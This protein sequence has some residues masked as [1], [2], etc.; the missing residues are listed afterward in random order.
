MSGPRR[1]PIKALV[2][3][4]G[5]AKGMVA[6][7]ALHY[8]ERNFNL[9]IISGTSIG[10]V[11]GALI[12]AG[13]P[14]AH[15]RDLA[16]NVDPSKTRINLSQWTTTYG[17]CN[18]STILEPAFIALEAK[19]GPDPTLA[20][21]VDVTGID[22][23]VCAGNVTRG[24]TTYFRAAT[25]PNLTLRKAISASCAV[26]CLFEAVEIAGEL[27][28]DGGGSDNLPHLPVPAELAQWTVCIRLIGLSF[29]PPPISGPVDFLL[30][31]TVLM[32]S[33]P[34]PVKPGMTYIELRA[35]EIPFVP[36]SGMDS[37]AVKYFFDRGY[38]DAWSLDRVISLED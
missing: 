32:T 10:S 5:G 22:L 30:R 34:H 26:P 6:L 11:I 21:Y 4:G 31:L 14:A 20:R 12:G 35:P 9:E 2:L 7:G 25:H 36:A 33:S 19:L 1:H 17:L 37:S 8:H 28:V 3:G 38:K 13:Y 24:V 29:N 23:V 15:I 16:L 27:Y 18:V